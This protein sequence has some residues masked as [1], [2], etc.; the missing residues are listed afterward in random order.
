MK[1]NLVKTKTLGLGV[2]GIARRAALFTLAVAATSIVLLPVTAKAAWPERPITVV[3]MYG[4][5][6]GTD[7]VIR[8]I[9]AE[10]AK[11][12][13]M[14]DAPCR[15]GLLASSRPS[16]ASVSASEAREGNE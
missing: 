7:T 8:T 6:G 4:A 15:F 14:G 2:S 1:K 10:M 5:G 13:G 11:A 12:T 9:T 16:D 3:V